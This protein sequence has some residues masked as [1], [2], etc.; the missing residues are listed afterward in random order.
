MSRTAIHVNDGILI[1]VNKKEMRTLLRKMRKEFE[2]TVTE[3]PDLHQHGNNI[4]K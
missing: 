2:V 1:S 4:N 3:N